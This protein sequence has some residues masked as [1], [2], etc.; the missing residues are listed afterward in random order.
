MRGGTERMAVWCFVLLVAFSSSGS[1][2]R[3]DA[4]K[5]SADGLCERAEKAERDARG[6]E[7]KSEER[8]RFLKGKGGVA[9]RTDPGQSGVPA[10]TRQ[11]VKAKIAQA[12]AILPQL[13]QG[14]AASLQDK[15]VVPGLS[16]YFTQM[17]STIGRT[18]QAVEGCLDAP[19]NCSVPPIFCSPPP[20]MPS[21][22]HMG[23]AAFIRQVQQSYA[24]AA[25]TAH[26]AC[27]NLNGEV[28]GEVERMKREGRAAG[29]GATGAGG[30]QAT[31]FGE[32]DLQL[33][34]AESLKRE[35]AQ[36][37]QEADSASGVRGYCG[38][39]TRAR[40]GADTAHALVEGFRT[41][42][43]RTK[44]E[45][46]LPYDAKVI[47]LKAGWERKWSKGPALEVPELPLPK[48]ATGAG[49]ETPLG[50]AREYL[51]ENAPAWWD[52][53]KSAYRRGDEEMQLTEYVQGM[54]RQM[55]EYVASELIDKNFGS[56]GK[57]LTTGYKIL[58]A[59]KTT[60]DEVGEILTDAPRV[61]A[62]GSEAETKEL[63]GRTDRVPLNFLNGLFDDVTGWFPSP[64]YKHSGRE[65]GPR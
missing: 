16:Q 53:T 43:R 15:G 42:G 51:N 35:A 22:N 26:Q 46:G 3:A 30:A 21:F 14:A 63:A 50:K 18:L 45:A 9:P 60:G 37:R 31:P 39:R 47:D 27:L 48:V 52:G 55:V 64:R 8:Q 5:G 7:R 41:G 10:A 56:L 2:A 59:V 24:Q 38:T 57:S 54:P 23:S 32:A 65:G 44:P 11:A 20:G 13:R 25:N 33:R 61:I 34:R 12:R 40:I 4:G 49:G 36:Y 6:A 28:L 17:E 29:A 58:K 19:E 1:P 62:L